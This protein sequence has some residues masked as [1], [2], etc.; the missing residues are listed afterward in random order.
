MVWVVMTC[1]KDDLMAFF[2]NAHCSV[3]D[4]TFGSTYKLQRILTCRQV[5]PV[6]PI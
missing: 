5:H 4:Q 1:I 3:N 6:E 2:L